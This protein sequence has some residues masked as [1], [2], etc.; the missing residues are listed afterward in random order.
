MGAVEVPANGHTHSG[1]GETPGLLGDLQSHTIERDGVV[2][3][4]GALF[5]VAQD[6]R[7]FGP[8]QRHERRVGVR[9]GARE[10]DIVVRDELVVE[11]AVGAFDRGDACGAEF[12]DQPIL[13]RAVGARPNWR[14]RNTAPPECRGERS[15]PI[16]PPSRCAYSHGSSW[17][18]RICLVASSSTTIK[19]W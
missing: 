8:G 5:L 12:V 13:D 18:Y 15:P 14:G 3:G 17:A 4:D 6:G 7:E 11:V 10:L 1:T 2:F 19:C 9:R 16:T